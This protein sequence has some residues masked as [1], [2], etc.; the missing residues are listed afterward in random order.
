MKREELIAQVKEKYADIASSESQQ[1][2][3][4]TT[5]DITPEAYYENLL[6]AVI[7]EISKGTFDNCRSGMEIVNAVAVD[8]TVLSEW[9]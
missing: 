1:N 2:F 3:T 4:Q 9:K 8:K 6:S 5:T 7:T